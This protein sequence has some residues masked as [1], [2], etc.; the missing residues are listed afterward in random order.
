M[1]NFHHQP[2]S[3]KIKNNRTL[4]ENLL[5]LSAQ[6]AFLWLSPLH[7]SF[8]SHPRRLGDYKKFQITK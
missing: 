4:K 1:E 7:L 2:I 6:E 3:I 5:A 8:L